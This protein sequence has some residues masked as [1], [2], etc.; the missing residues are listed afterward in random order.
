MYVPEHFREVAPSEIAPVIAAAPLA[1]IV[2]NTADG[3]VANH[4]PVLVAA[5]GALIGHV[6][7]ANDIHRTVGEGQEVLAIF[8]PADAYVSPNFYPSKAEHHRHVPTWNYQAVHVTGAIS[9]QHEERAKRA[10]VGL[11]TREHERRLNAERAW[12][13]ADAPADFMTDML[14]GIVAFRI[15]VQRVIAKSKLSQNREAR[16]YQGVIDGLTRNENR[17][18]AESMVRRIERDTV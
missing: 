10:V 15:E 7:L 3:L 4:I 13:M 8:R 1:C 17:S 2:A 5:D 18:L 6:A 9:F 12:R 14:A 11:L 16:D